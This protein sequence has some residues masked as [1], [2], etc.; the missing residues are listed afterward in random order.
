MKRPIITIP[1]NL[2][3]HLDCNWDI[4]WRAQSSGESNAGTTQ[5]VNN[6]FPR[7]VGSPKIHL[8]NTAI[9]QWQALRAQAQGRVGIYIVKMFDPIGFG[10]QN[11]FPN[12]VL[13]S[14]GEPFSTGNGYEYDPVCTAEA[15]AAP[16]STQIRINVAGIGVAPNIGQIMSH[17]DWPF[18]VTWV[19]QVSANVYDL[20][21]Q[22][23]LRSRIYAGDLINYRGRGRFEAVEEGMGNAAY[24]HRKFSRPTLQFREVLTR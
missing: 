7:W 15:N 1:P 9:S 18:V 10:V 6:A 11:P 23:P 8:H 24:E 20:G 14:T 21:I 5:I 17:D 2:L 13:H 3:R 4:D 19:M 16:G 12:G 22:M